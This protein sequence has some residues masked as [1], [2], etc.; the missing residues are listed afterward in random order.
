M[1]TKYGEQKCLWQAGRQAKRLA[2][3]RALEKNIYTNKLIT[4]TCGTDTS[5]FEIAHKF[6]VYKVEYYIL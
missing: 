6:R 2:K 4:K 5:Y 3:K 1:I